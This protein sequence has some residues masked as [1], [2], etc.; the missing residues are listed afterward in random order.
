[1][2]TVESKTITGESPESFAK[3]AENA[4]QKIKDGAD[5]WKVESWEVKLGHHSPGHV[6]VYRVRIKEQS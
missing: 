5:W 6:E 4:A 2:A 1:M 3:A